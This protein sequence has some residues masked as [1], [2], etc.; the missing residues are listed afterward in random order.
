[1][2]SCCW[3]SPSPLVVFKYPSQRNGKY[4]PKHQ[5]VRK[6]GHAL[7]YVGIIV[8]KILEN[9][10]ASNSGGI[11][12]QTHLAIAKPDHCSSAP[13]PAPLLVLQPASGCGKLY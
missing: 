6:C 5:P 7:D 4:D 3:L 8:W 13:A 12:N 1:M 11:L 2:N 10:R 9:Q